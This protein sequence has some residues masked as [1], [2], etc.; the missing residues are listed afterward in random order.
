MES[1]AN[2]KQQT[3]ALTLI[4]I[5]LNTCCIIDKS[6]ELIFDPGMMLEEASLVFL[7]NLPAISK[8]KKKRSDSKLKTAAFPC[9]WLIQVQRGGIRLWAL[10]VNHTA[11]PRRRHLSPNTKGSAPQGTLKPISPLTCNPSRS[12]KN[13]IV[14]SY[15]IH[16]RC[17]RGCSK[18]R[19]QWVQKFYEET[20]GS[21]LGK[22]PLFSEVTDDALHWETF[23]FLYLLS[24]FSALLLLYCCLDCWK[25]CKSYQQLHINFKLWRDGVKNCTTPFLL[26]NSQ[27][28]SM[29][30]QHLPPSVPECCA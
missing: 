18:E 12:R 10:S 2:N 3:V 28:W 24:E 26:N 13:R 16:F 5:H 7:V 9:R 6:V 11:L 1:F 14:E 29:G 21:V 23:T 8:R 20:W 22:L 17:K 4:L 25:L 19:E 30:S 27:N 15:H